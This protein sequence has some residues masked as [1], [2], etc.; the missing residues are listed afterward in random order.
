MRNTLPPLGWV[1]ELDTSLAGS[2]GVSIEGSNATV[3]GDDIYHSLSSNTL[4]LPPLSP[5]GA[6]S[7]YIDIF[8][9]GPSS[10]AWKVS[11]WESYV[12]ANPSSGITGSNGSDTRVLITIS[13]WAAT[14][15]A[16]NSSVVRINITS[17]CNWGNYGAPTIVFPVNHT[18]APTNFTGF[19]EDDAHISIEAEHTKSNTSTSSSQYVTLSNYGRT[20]SGVT[21]F[22]VT[23]PSQDTDTGPYLS[24][25]IYTFTPATLANLT[26][27]ISPS[28]NAN[29]ASRPLK[30]GVAI[31]SED[32]Q[33]VE[34]VPIATAGSLPAGWD[35]AVSDGVWGLSSGNTTTTTHAVDAGAHE[36]KLWLLEPGV[37]V[38]KLVLDLGGVRSSYLG[39]PES[40]FVS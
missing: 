5:Y 3:P 35:G 17:D 18:S 28:L 37:V 24:Y 39:P 10:C 16:P 36:V 7:R 20:L 2:L 6:K 13:D 15:S 30:Y 9:R 27:Y 23:L 8:S 40:E 22:P 34:F 31:D 12:S 1:Q 21:L 32:P 25:S 4:T 14:P 26:L 11:P 19:I 29:G 33:I 38:Q